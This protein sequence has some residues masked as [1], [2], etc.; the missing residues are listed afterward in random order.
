M[1]HNLKA[2][3]KKMLAAGMMKSAGCC[4]VTVI[5]RAQLLL[6]GKVELKAFAGVFTV[7]DELHEHSA[8]RAVQSHVHQLCTGEDAQQTGT[9][10][11]AI[12]HL[13]HTHTHP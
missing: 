11:A 10:T 2:V 3:K 13:K 8:G 12:I 1:L 4:N 7:T 5:K 6:T 9:V